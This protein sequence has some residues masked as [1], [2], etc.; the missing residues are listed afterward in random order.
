MSIQ[1]FKKISSHCMYNLERSQVSKM[2]GDRKIMKSERFACITML[3]SFQKTQKE[4][5]GRE[6]SNIKWYWNLTGS[7]SIFFFHIL[8][9]VNKMQ[10][11]VT[12]IGHKNTMPHNLCP[13]RERN[14][15]TESTCLRSLRR[16][17]QVNFH[18]QLKT[19][20]F[21]LFLIW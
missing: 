17:C 5:T 6:N 4:M 11:K 18:V 3:C 19:K 20:Y 15:S 8:L 10:T 7:V 2:R 13:I 14:W 12:V 21:F 16:A 1:L 9:T